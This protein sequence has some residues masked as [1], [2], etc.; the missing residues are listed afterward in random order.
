MLQSL[1]DDA[2]TDAPNWAS[3]TRSMQLVVLLVILVV[4]LL[5]VLVLLLLFLLG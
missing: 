4:V 1:L 3:A 5:F 2:V